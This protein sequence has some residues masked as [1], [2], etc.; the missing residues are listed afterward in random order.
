MHGDAMSTALRFLPALVVTA[1]ILVGAYWTIGLLP[2]AVGGQRGLLS[3]FGTIDLDALGGFGYGRLALISLVSLFLELLL[4]RW[5]SSEIRVFAFFK[6]LVLIACFLGFGL[7]CYVTRAKIYLGY[8]LVPLIALVL[9]IELPW[10]A[11]RQLVAS[12]SDF[13]GA[14]SDIHI[15]SML[16]FQSSA[17]IRFGSLLVAFAVILSVFGLV[18]IIFVPLG[19]AIGWYLERAGDGVRAYSVNVTASIVGIWL[20]TL[21]CFAWS[22]PIVWVAL[23]GVLLLVYVWPLGGVRRPALV[24]VAVT[25]ALMAAGTLKHQWWAADWKDSSTVPTGMTAEA[26]LKFWSPYQKLTVIPLVYHGDTNAY[27]LNTNDSWYQRLVDLSPATVAKYPELYKDTPVAFHQY[28]LPYRFF[29][30]PPSVLIAGAGAGNDAAGAVR[31]GAGRVTAVEI[32]PLIYDIGRHRHFEHPYAQDNVRVVVDDARAFVQNTTEQY[33][34]IIFSILDS[35]TTSSYYT[36]IRLDNY[37]YTVEALQAVKRHLKPGGLFVMSFSGGRAWFAG[38][39]HAVVTEAFGHPPLMLQAGM[40]YFVA[41]DTARIQG[42]LAADTALASFVAA[43][44]NVALAAAS[45]STDDWPYLYQQY[46]GIP[47]IVWFL[48]GGLVLICALAIRRFKKSSAPF[49]WHFFFLGAAFMLLEVQIISKAALLFGTT[50]LVNSIIITAL[51]AFILLANLV[52]RRMPNFPRALVY[53]G[54]F[55]TLALAYFVPPESL[56]SPSMLV[57][58][59]LVAAVYCSPVF[60]AGLVFIS[61]FRAIG[62]Q[63]EA[64]GANLLGSLVGGLLES[65]SYATGIRALVIMAALLYLAS[66]ATMRRGVAAAAPAAAT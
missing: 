22:P 42:A 34:L 47:T 62:F 56:F 21:L 58:G 48:S 17:V 54:L 33:D 50:W 23:F 19:Q 29:P 4:I 59:L 65:A 8:T 28:N 30:R 61:S 2:P 13:I 32:D 41:G 37:V 27:L 55:V 43:R 64:F 49:M 44:Q 57:R 14:A 9:L 11:L 31:N 40:Y 26:P 18:A 36:N 52:V 24:S 10:D 45:T 38:R 51:L 6:S 3:R 60:F 16:H 5:V 66:L 1:L 39:L 25:V 63:A 53:A 35:H 20:Y 46:R 15:W 12:L 7:G